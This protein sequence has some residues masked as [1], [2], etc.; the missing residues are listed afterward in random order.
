MSRRL[1]SVL[2]AAIVAIHGFGLLWW[3]AVASSYSSAPGH[4][5]GQ[6][7]L[8]G[9]QGS[10]S[11]TADDSLGASFVVLSHIY[12]LLF[13]GD[14]SDVEML[15]GK[16]RE[17]APDILILAGD[18]ITGTWNARKPGP[19]TFSSDE[20]LKDSLNRQWDYVFETFGS[21]DVPV[22]I[23]PGNHDISSSTPRYRPLVREVFNER[24]G[25]PFFRKQLRNY[26]FIFVNTTLTKPAAGQQ[27]AGLDDTQ[28]EWLQ[29][30]LDA[31][32]E[33]TDF[34]FLHH[35]LW[36]SG[37][38]ANPSNARGDKMASVDWMRSMH[39]SLLGKVKCVFAGDGGQYGNYLFFETRDD[40]RY[41]IN[42]SG[43][44]GVTFL[45]VV[46]TGERVAVNPYFLPIEPRTPQPS[47][48]F[49]DRVLRISRH[50]YFWVGVGV[51]LVATAV[52]IVLITTLS[53]VS[54]RET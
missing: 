40:I 24:V 45:H 7:Q 50:R 39:P 2:A 49:R 16:I 26:R 3:P 6:D 20:D 21:L 52:V 1:R 15:V 5:I 32:S 47:S 17:R 29:G 31:S 14:P 10:S 48:S 38:E 41:Y 27:I 30:E 46:A 53:K 22:W 11:D 37:V 33:S 34:L 4:Q 35:A 36:Y 12:P 54:R 8:V 28:V 23:C 9:A 44:K 13:D 19:I 18:I 43:R 42:G 51:G 25:P